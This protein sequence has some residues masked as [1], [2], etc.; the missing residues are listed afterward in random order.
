MTEKHHGNSAIH[1]RKYISQETTA[2][3]SENQIYQQNDVNVEIENNKSEGNPI[4]HL[5]QNTKKRNEQEILNKMPSA[6]SNTIF[7]NGKT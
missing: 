1:S 6:Y 3:Q 4:K 2:N 7:R 5:T